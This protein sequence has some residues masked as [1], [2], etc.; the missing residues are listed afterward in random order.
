MRKKGGVKPKFAVILALA[1]IV[2]LL[3]YG[4][5]S[6][7]FKSDD[8]SDSLGAV[9]AAVSSTN[10]PDKGASAN[11]SSGAPV[12]TVASWPTFEMKY[13]NAGAENNLVVKAEYSITATT[14]K[15]FVP[16][17]WGNMWIRNTAYQGANPTKIEIK[18]LDA[19]AVTTCNYVGSCYIIPTGK[20]VRFI[21]RQ[22]YNP[23]TMFSGLYTG[24]LSYLHYLTDSS[25]GNFH[26]TQ[27]PD[28]PGKLDTITV[29]GEKS[30]YLYTTNVTV[31]SGQQFGIKG[32]RLTGSKPVLVNQEN[33]AS[34]SV[35]NQT[36][37]DATAWMDALPGVYSVY[38][39]HPTYGESNKLLINVIPPIVRVVSPNGG[40]ALMAGQ[41]Y[42]IIWSPVTPTG[43]VNIWLL[44]APTR[45]GKLIFSGTVDDGSEVWKAFP[46]TSLVDKEGG[47]IAPSGTYVIHIECSDYSCTSDAS[48]SYFKIYIKG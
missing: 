42:K 21:A 45:L 34:F 29:V 46:L 18:S 8:V 44:D 31:T 14:K 4:Y 26:Y 47:T 3:W 12:I 15:I 22:V 28:Q 36:D 17:S 48:D 41:L 38:F 37:T 16:V 5:K 20:T 43:K 19:L 9:S 11:T 39:S 32:A 2:V 40:E 6:N 27:F 30:P 7:W 13:N 25:S 1:V 23:L 35:V 33:P 24:Q 10:A